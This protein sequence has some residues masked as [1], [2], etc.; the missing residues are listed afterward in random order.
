FNSNLPEV[1]GDEEETEDHHPIS[2]TKTSVFQFPHVLLGVLALFLYVGVEVI[3]G[4][5]I[6]KY[7]NHLNI[8]LSIAKFFTAGTMAAMWQGIL[9]ELLSFQN[10][11]ANLLP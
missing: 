3:A 11:S 2:E 4:D 7:G 9:W 10:I 6:I 1:S 5:T 8:P